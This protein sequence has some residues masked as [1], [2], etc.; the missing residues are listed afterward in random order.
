MRWRE[1]DDY[2]DVRPGDAE[3]TC[4][5]CGDA[6]PD[7]LDDGINR[8]CSRECWINAGGGET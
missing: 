2:L 1:T 8:Y 3:G 7:E 6:I 4:A 5:F